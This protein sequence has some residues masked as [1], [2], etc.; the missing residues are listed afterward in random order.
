MC[1]ITDELIWKSRF[2]ENEDKLDDLLKLRD[3]NKIIKIID[4]INESSF[5]GEKTIENI[6]SSE[7]FFDI[8][9]VSGSSE[10]KDVKKYLSKLYKDDPYCCFRP[11][12]IIQ[13]LYNFFYSP[14]EV[15]AI[16]NPKMKDSYL[17][18]LTWAFYIEE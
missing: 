7:I 11:K 9:A 16:L 4:Y 3:F 14:D 5:P 8:K 17:S 10:F 18:F 15:V 1:R 13:T 2:N 12:D 6:L